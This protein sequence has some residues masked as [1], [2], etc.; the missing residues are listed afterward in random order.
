MVYSHLQADKWTGYKADPDDYDVFINPFIVTKDGIE[1]RQESCPS[2][3]LFRSP[4]KRAKSIKVQFVDV[5]NDDAEGE[6]DGF[7]ARVFQHEI[8]HLNGNLISQMHINESQGEFEEDKLDPDMRRKVDALMRKLQ[9]PIA[10]PN[11]PKEGREPEEQ[12]F[13][14]PSRD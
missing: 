12:P 13:K 4:I 3:P 2:V 7:A 8:D 1:I 5:D 11:V 9:S 14:K 6:L 10:K